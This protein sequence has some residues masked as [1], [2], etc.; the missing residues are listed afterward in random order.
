MGPQIYRVYV[1]KLEFFNENIFIRS[2]LKNL[3]F[4]N[5]QNE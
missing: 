1:K 2:K 3:K 5:F 4:K